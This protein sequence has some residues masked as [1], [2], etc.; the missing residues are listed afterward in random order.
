MEETS[1]L[2]AQALPFWQ[3]LTEE[4]QTQ[5]VQSCREQTVPRGDV[6]H[7]PRQGC[8]GLQL[9]CEGQ[10]RVYILS[11]EGRQVT[12]YRVYAGQVCVMSSS[13]LLDS[14]VFDVF[15]EA[16]EDTRLLTLPSAAL[17]P[18]LQRR[19]EAELYLYKT[20]THR[21]SEVMWRVQQ[22]LFLAA[23]RRVAIF[24]W[25]EFQRTGP[26]LRLTQEEI[27]RYIGSARE[28]VS[29]VLKYFVQEGMV[30]LERGQIAL[31]DTEKLRRLAQM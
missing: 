28:V 10:L 12:L 17:A 26:V 6:T 7:R 19:P 30:T 22:I 21:F 23:D 24:L 8:R 31:V 3:Q 9:V 14:L 11:E 2:W 27:A 16:V 5:L 13:C 29:K 25:E 1:R 15:V 4:E 20:A 18:V